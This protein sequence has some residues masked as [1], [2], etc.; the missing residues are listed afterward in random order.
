MKK[1]LITN[2]LYSLFIFLL[3]KKEKIENYKCIF[4][5]DISSIKFG[6]KIKNYRNKYI[7]KGKLNWLIEI[8]EYLYIRYLVGFNT[9][10]I[11]GQD[12]IRLGNKCLFF[13]NFTLLEDGTL[14]Y[15]IKNIEIS[16]NRVKKFIKEKIF[17]MYQTHGIHENVKKIYLTGLAPIPKEIEHKVEL[18]N[19]KELWNKKSFEEK[20]EIL[21]IF[22]FDKNI[23]EK[24][25]GRDIILF[26]QPLSEDD[27]IT[28]EEK[29]NIYKEIVKKYPKEKLI[30]KTHPREKTNYKERFKDY[31]VLDNPFPFEILNLL[32]VKFSKG[33]T[34][35]STAA[36]SLG[37]DVEV[38]FYGT[39]VHPKI[40]NRFGSCDN[41]KKRNVFLDENFK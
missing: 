4:G 21:D 1:I 24:I 17:G 40:F 8:Y 13:N 11:I 20:E 35:F 15:E 5:N 34:L 32:E 3:V 9:K 36:L 18:I 14:S 37:E 25:K 12:H 2:T 28:E 19:L 7:F 6:K 10:E 27:V 23:E 41:L 26:T 16:K 22:S 38:D 33:V 29:I 30:I 31:L 39:E